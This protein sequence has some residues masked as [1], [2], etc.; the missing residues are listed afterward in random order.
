MLDVESR[1]EAFL[2]ASITRHK[3]W[4]ATIDGAP[5]SIAPANI[6]FQGITVPPGKH[7]VELRYRNPLILP[8]AIASLIALIACIAAYALSRDSGRG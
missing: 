4:R 2:I 3:Y 5:V 1:G 7:R 8:A 6:A